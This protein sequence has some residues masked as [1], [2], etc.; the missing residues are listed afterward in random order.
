M[1][2]FSTLPGCGVDQ[3]CDRAEDRTREE[4]NEDRGLLADALKRRI[5]ETGRNDW[6]QS[7]DIGPEAGLTGMRASNIARAFPRYFQ[8]DHMSTSRSNRI[9]LIRLHPDLARYL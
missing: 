2:T 5:R 7:T 3:V 1:P 9:T 6:L 8:T 4:C